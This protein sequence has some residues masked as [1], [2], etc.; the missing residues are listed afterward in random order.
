MREGW[1]LGLLIPLRMPEWEGQEH[2]QG[3]AKV[4]LKIFD[5]WG[6]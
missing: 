2:M 4:L 6:V 5:F 3:Q 1:G